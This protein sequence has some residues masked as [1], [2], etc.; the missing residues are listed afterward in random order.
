MADESRIRVVSEVDAPRAPKHDDEANERGDLFGPCF[1]RSHPLRVAALKW[2]GSPVFIHSILFV[3]ACNLLMLAMY[4]PLEP[5]SINYVNLVNI[6]FEPIFFSIFFF[7]FV[8]KVTAMGARAYAADPGNV[9]DFIIIILSLLALIPSLP[10][11][12]ALRAMRIVRLFVVISS[13]ALLL[14]NVTMSSVL[15]LRTVFY[16]LL[17]V[18]SMFAIIAVHSARGALNGSCASGDPFFVREAVISASNKSLSIPWSSFPARS[19]VMMLNVSDK[20]C[21]LPCDPYGPV[22]C[23]P[24]SQ[25]RSCPKV[26]VTKGAVTLPAMSVCVAGSNPEYGS[27]GFDDFLMSLLAVFQITTLEGWFDLHTHLVDSIG[28]PGLLTVY[29]LAIIFAGNYWL[30]SIVVASVVIEFDREEA[31][32][33]KSADPIRNAI[34]KVGGTL[35]PSA[36]VACVA[37][38][39]KSRKNTVNHVKS[40]IQ[41][42]TLTIRE[43]LWAA[44]VS[45][46][47]LF[48]V[49]PTF[50]AEPLNQVVT[51]PWYGTIIMAAILANAVTLALDDAH[52]S[53]AVTNALSTANVVFTLTFCLDLLMRTLAVGPVAHFSDTSNIFDAI[54]VVICF[55][56][57]IVNLVSP[58]FAGAGLS[59]L[60]VL[61]AFRVLKIS[62]SWK[63]MEHLISMMSSMTSEI[64]IALLLFIFG[65]FALSVAGLQLM[66][67]AYEAHLAS[68]K[69][70]PD[71]NF[72]TLWNAFVTTFW[73]LTKE[74]WDT[75]M[76]VHMSMT[77]GFIALF[78]VALVILGNYIFLNIIVALVLERFRAAERKLLEVQEDLHQDV[79]PPAMPSLVTSFMDVARK[80]MATIAFQCRLRCPGQCR[81]C[82]GCKFGERDGEDESFPPEAVLEL[83]AKRE[84]ARRLIRR[85]KELASG[86]FDSP[87]AVAINNPMRASVSKAAAEASRRVTAA[88]MSGLRVSLGDVALSALV[89]NKRDNDGDELT[90]RA[91][92]AAGAALSAGYVNLLEAENEAKEW[93]APVIGDTELPATGGPTKNATSIDLI[94]DNCDGIASGAVIHIP[95]GSHSIRGVLDRP[96][97]RIQ[98][99][100]EQLKVVS[101]SSG[102]TRPSRAFDRRKNILQIHQE[103][104]NELLDRDNMWRGPKVLKESDSDLLHAR[105]CH[106]LRPADIV[107]TELEARLTGV[108]VSAVVFSTGA[109]S[110]SLMRKDSRHRSCGVFHHDDSFRVN[111]HKFVSSVPVEAFLI[112]CIIWSSINLAIEEPSTDACAS[113]PRSDPSSCIDFK[114]YI[115]VSDIIMTTAFVIEMILKMIAQGILFSRYAYLRDPWGVLDFICVFVSILSL[116]LS[117]SSLVVSSGVKALRIVRTLRALR[118]LRMVSRFEN[119]RV[120]VSTLVSSLSKVFSAMSVVFVIMFIFAIV[121]MQLFQSTISACN[122]PD[123][124]R[125]TSEMCTGTWVLL[126]NAC[127][128][129]PSAKA[130]ELC[131][132][133]AGVSFP[134]LWQSLPHNWDTFSNSLWI[135]FANIACLED[136]PSR[137]NEAIASTGVGTGLV[138]GANG[139]NALFFIAAIF[140]LP[141]FLIQFV[142]GIVVEAYM[143]QK[144]HG[145]GQMLLSPG[146]KVWSESIRAALR[147][148]PRHAILPAGDSRY[149]RLLSVIARSKAYRFLLVI[150]FT[151]NLIILMISHA[152]MSRTMERSL[153]IGNYVLTGLFI[154]DVLLSIACRGFAVF[155]SGWDRF[156]AVCV[157]LR[158]VAIIVAE[159]SR[160]SVDDTMLRVAAWIL[161]LVSIAHQFRIFQFSSAVRRSLNFFMLTLPAFKNVSALLVLVIFFYAVMGMNL[162]AG[163]RSNSGGQSM[164]SRAFFTNFYSSRVLASSSNFDTFLSSAWTLVRVM[165]GERFSTLADDLG[166]QPPYCVNDDKGSDLCGSVIGGRIFLGTFVF[167][168][169]VFLLKLLFAAVVSIFSSVSHRNTT[170]I[171]EMTHTIGHQWRRAW[172]LVDSQATGLIFLVDLARVLEAAPDELLAFK[173]ALSDDVKEND[174]RRKEFCRNLARNLP[175]SADELDRVGFHGVL[176]ALLA[177]A[178]GQECMGAP[179]GAVSMVGGSAAPVGFTIKEMASIV[180]FQRQV[181]AFLASKR[182]SAFFTSLSQE[183]AYRR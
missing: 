13:R 16:I 4:R 176:L 126:G 113:L 171:V 5:D 67:P 24:S 166:V 169:N 131:R 114:F 148:R 40:I 101:V 93:S 122:D 66:G 134:R 160:L 14:S 91:I 90:F 151:S 158:A 20:R 107:E 8:V 83:A 87:A 28:S 109:Y 82:G 147:L 11:A 34:S 42:G 110:L 88:K 33:Q 59:A 103:T 72:S 163:I 175:V 15:A 43:T 172:S 165:T 144:K 41:G 85:L 116:S 96:A 121:G 81:I 127:A 130:E 38:D 123:P 128:L 182:Q 100:D 39:I 80:S 98:I 89:S 1:S 112:V 76:H 47:N 104:R 70:L 29:M 154:F 36:V 77:G 183:E 27:L 78:F 84:L 61:R 124:S 25:G 140:L 170:G 149:R 118:P 139:A 68:G 155:S 53:L 143:Y 56:D 177:H 178:S 164:E 21:G 23:V 106:P 73:V 174:S 161:S 49:I 35:F 111:A 60:R 181:R 99:F 95:S 44:F 64:A 55:V 3:A 22:S 133:S 125:Q 51:N 129:L 52:A 117:G 62:S 137:M 152:G 32:V 146:Q 162:F 92:H 79:R 150:L 45:V 141:W 10:N 30:L 136:W 18:L 94:S 75:V 63:P 86:F 120:I 37:E 159:F 156:N 74:R 6:V 54:I 138:P 9:L 132:A 69:R 7:E 157:V 12:T 17:L 57:L 119:L 102:K 97:L 179:L 105:R 26:Y 108:K 168:T 135:V 48:P 46:C 142:T 31:S 65:V 173:A 153:G 71:G 115:Y 58:D 2:M 180:F 19:A 50:V 167:M 145:L